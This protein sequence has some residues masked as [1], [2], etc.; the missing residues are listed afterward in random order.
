MARARP[1]PGAIAPP[2]ARGRSAPLPV[3]SDHRPVPAARSS[4][5]IER[6][7]LILTTPDGGRRV[8]DA[9]WV[10]FAVRDASSAQRFVR[11]LSL[12]CE[13]GAFWFITPPEAGAIAPRALGLPPAPTEASVLDA[14]VW[15]TLA[16]WL[17]GGGRLHGK[18]IAE[19]ARLAR[20]ATSPFAIAIGEVAARAASEM[21]WERGGPMR[22]SEVGAR[23]LLRPLEDAAQYSVRAAEALVAAM[24]ARGEG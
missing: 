4:L 20:V 7:R 19:L 18:T 9:H 22:S 24:A 6:S 8:L 13:S 17:R 11:E 10:R 5:E 21:S 2:Q 23:E 15:N 1:R 3:R 12:E 16:D 14:E